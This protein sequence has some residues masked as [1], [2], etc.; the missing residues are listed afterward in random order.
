LRTKI[1]IR[2]RVQGIANVFRER[3]ALARDLDKPDT[4]GG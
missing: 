4:N 1:G 3:L 2:I